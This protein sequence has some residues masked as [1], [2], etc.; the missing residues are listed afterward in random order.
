MYW[1]FIVIPAL[2]DV[3]GTLSALRQRMPRPPRI[4]APV[5]RSYFGVNG[6]DE[7]PGGVTFDN[8]EAPGGPADKAGLVGGDIIQ[9]F[10]GHRVTDADEL[11][12]L[13]R[14]TPIGKTVAVTYLP[15][16]EL[17]TTQLT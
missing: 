6:F 16:V 9:T 12:D 11:G 10:D 1:N 13:L 5:H 8:V 7:V 15:D 17:K 2:F 3:G 4:V 14:Q